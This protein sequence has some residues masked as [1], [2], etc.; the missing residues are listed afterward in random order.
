MLWVD[1]FLSKIPQ[2]MPTPRFELTQKFAFYQEITVCFTICCSVVTVVTIVM[3]NHCFATQNG[4]PHR[5]QVM[6]A[7]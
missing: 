5:L 4:C 2:N 3:L 7:A 6:Q 1:L